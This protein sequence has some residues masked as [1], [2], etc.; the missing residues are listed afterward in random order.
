MVKA[1]C[2]SANAGA[3]I[4]IDVAVSVPAM[5]RDPRR[6]LTFIVRDPPLADSLTGDQFCYSTL[7]LRYLEISASRPLLHRYFTEAPGTVLVVE[8]SWA[9]AT[10]RWRA[11]PSG[12]QV[13][14][15]SIGFA[16]WAMTVQSF[17]SVTYGLAWPSTLARIS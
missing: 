11:V 5:A 4:P 9:R 6:R 12:V 2:G 3:A 15:V 16:V 7:L 1:M 13:L 10:R 8:T 17:G 14:I